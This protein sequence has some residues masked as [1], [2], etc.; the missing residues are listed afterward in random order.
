MELPPR[1]VIGT[2]SV[3]RASQLLSVRPDIITR[4]IRGNVE[5]RIA[6]VI[7]SNLGY[8]AVVLA[9]AGLR[10]LERDDAIT[11][12]LDDDIML[13]APGQG[14][15]AVQCRS[16][17]T[18]I[19]ALLA[20]IDHSPTRAEVTAEREFLRFLNAG[21][22]TPVAC[23][24]RW[25]HGRLIFKGRCLSP[26]GGKKIEVGAEDAAELAAELG[27]RMGAEAVKLGYAGL[28]ATVGD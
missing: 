2:S 5:T 20:A 7:D 4:S 8:D 6:K 27:R 22:N 18:E 17:A 12:L 25:S 28:L 3:R 1:S 10:R 23:R 19:R 14:A 9:E 15:L 11:E 26:N 16:S 13:P 21:C 24:A